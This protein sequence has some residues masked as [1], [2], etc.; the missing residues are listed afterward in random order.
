MLLYHFT[1]AAD[2]P[3]VLASGEIQPRWH[4]GSS[5]CTVH[6]TN[7]PDRGAL[8]WRLR[9][10]V[11]RIAVDVPDSDA[12]PWLPWAGRYLPPEE[13]FS[14]MAPSTVNQW[15]GRPECWFVVERPI[16]M[17]EW[18]CVDDVAEGASLWVADR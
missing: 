12:H 16:R 15:N 6:L 8:P 10:R 14:L 13:H 1:E 9:D 11:V 18:T 4:R 2:W 7:D 17:D 3:G 5:P